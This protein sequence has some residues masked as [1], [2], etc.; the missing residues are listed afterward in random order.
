MPGKHLIPNILLAIQV[1][2]LY[3]IN[4][5]HIIKAISEYKTLDKRMDII[6]LKKNNTLI[7]D[8]YNSSYESLIGVLELIK[9]FK[10]IN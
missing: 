4:I 10:L 5:K 1:G 3:G 8:C 7:A 6:K 9:M 2:L